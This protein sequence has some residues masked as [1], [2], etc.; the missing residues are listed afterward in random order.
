MQNTAAGNRPALEQ[1]RT[2]ATSTSA[3][4]ASQYPMP[5][6]PCGQ[7]WHASAAHARCPPFCEGSWRV[8]DVMPDRGTL[9]G[10]L[11][12]FSSTLKHT[13]WSVTYRVPWNAICER[14]IKAT[15][16][17]R[18]N[19][20]SLSEERAHVRKFP[21]S[22][23][24]ARAVSGCRFQRP[25]LHQAEIDHPCMDIIAGQEVMQ[26]TWMDGVNVLCAHAYVC[27]SLHLNC[28]TRCSASPSPNI[29]CSSLLACQHGQKEP[30]MQLEPERSSH[31]VPPTVHTPCGTVRMLVTQMKA[32]VAVHWIKCV[33]I[34]WS[35]MLII[36]R[37]VHCCMYV[38]SRHQHLPCLQLLC[39]GQWSG[40][41]LW[42]LCPC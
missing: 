41:L 2:A 23:K 35:T 7:P 1:L 36:M 24:A 17:Q 8:A 42:V 16:S 21:T 10:R 39:A 38:C 6:V 34:C 5:M 4:P 28:S 37:C 13:C 27:S 33:R 3:L 15:Q 19:A 30:D 14:P 40:C 11:R 26:P 32:C 12:P 20:R 22:D 9:T 25:L 29:C 18:S 31:C